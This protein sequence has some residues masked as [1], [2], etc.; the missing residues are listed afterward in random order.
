MWK[1]KSAGVIVELFL[2]EPVVLCVER[3]LLGDGG[4]VAVA[5]LHP[6]RGVDQVEL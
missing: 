1:I 2:Y 5:L 4:L 3:Q 6:V